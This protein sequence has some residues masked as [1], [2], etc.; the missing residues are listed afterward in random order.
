MQG[1]GAGGKS[2][3]SL[4]QAP[5]APTAT[6]GAADPHKQLDQ[7]LRLGH[8]NDMVTGYKQGQ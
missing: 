6:Q 1:K 4:F 7:G 8:A 3:F 5:E 2:S